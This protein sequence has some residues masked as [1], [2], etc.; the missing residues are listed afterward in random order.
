MTKA[1]WAA[2]I[3]VA[4]GLCL[5]GGGAANSRLRERFLD[6]CIEIGVQP[7]IPSRSMCTDNAAMVAAAGWW[8]LQI[9]GSSPLNVGAN[10]N[11]GL[12]ERI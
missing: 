1:K 7:F 5:G 9:D 12:P 4:N 2:A 6:M 10:P 8:C 3:T 11:W